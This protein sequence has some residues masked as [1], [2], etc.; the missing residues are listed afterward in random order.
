MK[1]RHW[2]NLIVV[3]LTAGL[4]AFL[5]LRWAITSYAEPTCRRFAESQGTTY[6]GFIP[7]DLS[8][9][10]GPSHMSRDGNC[11][12]RASNDEVQIVSLVAASRPD[13]GAPLLVHFALGWEFIF[14]ASFIGVA[15]ILAIVTRAITPRRATS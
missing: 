7:P 15:F 1:M 14:L 6:V 9:D 5:A 8:Q 4:L 13:Y 12:L 3:G 11:Q 2:I 10:T